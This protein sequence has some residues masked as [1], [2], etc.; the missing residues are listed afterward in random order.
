M[1][2]IEQQSS[3]RKLVGRSNLRS[4][5]NREIRLKTGYQR[6]GR[7]ARVI[8]SQV[9]FMPALTYPRANIPGWSTTGS[10]A[11]P[12]SG[13]LR[14]AFNAANEGRPDLSQDRQPAR[15]ATASRKGDI[16]PTNNRLKH[17]SLTDFTPA[18][19]RS[20][21]LGGGFSEAAPRFSLCT[22][23]TAPLPAFRR[24]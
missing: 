1:C 19:A 22:N 2:G 12:R 8:C 6:S 10:R 3:K 23:L 4:P 24:G 11:R 14:H 9:G 21:A 16:L 20:C 15:S 7:L 17:A 18:L 5:S 13:L